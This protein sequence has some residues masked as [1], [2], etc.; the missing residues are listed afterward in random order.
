MLSVEV[1]IQ[2]ICISFV[3]QM[4]TQKSFFMYCF[5]G[6][7]NYSHSIMLIYFKRSEIIIHF[8][9]LLH[10]ICS[11][12]SCSSHLSL[13]YSDTRDISYTML[14]Q[15]YCLLQK[16]AESTFL[17]MVCVFNF[18]WKFACYRL[19]II[20]I[21]YIQCYTKYFVTNTEKDR[22]FLIR[23]M[24]FQGKHHLVS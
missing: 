20:F 15:K 12:I 23:Y 7:N 9:G 6:T 22:G 3:F 8:C 21:Y 11:R 17:F 2:R 4:A 18:Y 19:C 1:W 5:K 16:I 24:H 14:Y 13:T 10:D